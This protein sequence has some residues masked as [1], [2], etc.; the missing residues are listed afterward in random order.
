[1]SPTEQLQIGE[2]AKLAGTTTH[3][4]RIWQARY[5]WP[6]PEQDPTNGYRYYHRHLVDQI[7][8]AV[9]LR[10]SGYSL[11]RLIVDGLPRWP[12]VKWAR[13]TWHQ[14]DQLAHAA[15]GD[16]TDFRDR[17]HEALRARAMAEIEA[18][19]HRTFIVL[20]PRDRMMASWAPAVFGALEWELYNRPLPRDVPQLVR[21]LAGE[22]TSSTLEEWWR[23]ACERTK[24]LKRT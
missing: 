15:D 17:L 14:Y 21:R 16:A 3:V 8:R 23:L 11:K 22:A 2:V 20:C 1:M 6:M 12:D 13:D 5:G 10:R 9:E 7:R 4:L 19:L 24:Q 18:A